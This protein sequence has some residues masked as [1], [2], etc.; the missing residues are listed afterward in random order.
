MKKIVVS[1]DFFNP[2]DTL[3]C[4]QVFRYFDFNG[5]YVAFSGDKACFL[6]TE[7]ENVL[8]ECSEA[9]EKYFYN[10]FDLA[11]DYSEIVA[12]ACESGAEVLKTAALLGKGVRI[13]RQKGEE[14]LLSFVI[15]QN[16][17]IPRIKK[18][19]EGLCSAVGNKKT[20][21]LA[22]ET[23]QYYAFPEASELADKTEDFYLNLGFGYRARYMCEVVRA[24][25]G[26]LL[27]GIENLSFSEL[28]KRLLEVK[29][30]GEKVADCACLFGFHKTDSFPVDVWLERV[31][32]QDFNGSLTDRKKISEYFVSRF[33][34]DSGFFQQ[35]L[36]YYKRSLS[37][38]R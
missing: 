18:L 20:A 6:K 22:G 37:G 1:G 21:V 13:L 26:G 10:Y 24:I 27:C 16:N 14:A 23:V 7:G 31:Y 17:N 33:K 38:N 25:N 12:R 5:G 35:Y 8:V 34:S 11:E 32:K 30:V 9:D 3:N 15:S 4:G 2:A 28:K 19:I 36:F 29:G